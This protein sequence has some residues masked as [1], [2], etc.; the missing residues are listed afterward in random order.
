MEPCLIKF[1]ERFLAPIDAQTCA[2]RSVVKDAS[3]LREEISWFD[4]ISGLFKSDSKSNDL[5]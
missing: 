5:I 4:I 3:I 2:I 1:C